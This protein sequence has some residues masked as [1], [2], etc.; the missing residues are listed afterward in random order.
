MTGIAGSPPDLR[1]VPSGCAFHP[2]CPHAL[3]RCSVDV[4]QLVPLSPGPRPGEVAGD[5]GRPAL[6]CWLHEESPSSPDELAAAGRNRT[7]SHVAWFAGSA[8]LPAAGPESSGGGP[9]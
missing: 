5:S 1:A 2:R 4:P 6:A 8:P 7:H 9:R 3:E